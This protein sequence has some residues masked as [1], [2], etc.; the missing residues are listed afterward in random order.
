[1]IEAPCGLPFRRDNRPQK[2]DSTT[3]RIAAGFALVLLLPMVCLANAVPAYAET[4]FVSAVEGDHFVYLPPQP[5]Q[6]ILLVAHGT[7]RKSCLIIETRRFRFGP[8]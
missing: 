5:A 8:T 2:H 7:L 6:R 3:R 1:V 4:R